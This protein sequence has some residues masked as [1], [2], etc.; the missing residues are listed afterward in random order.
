MFHLYL[1]LFSEDFVEDVY[2]LNDA[3]NSLFKKPEDVDVNKAEEEDEAKMKIWTRAVDVVLL[4][5]RLLEAA[6][7]TEVL[8]RSRD[9]FK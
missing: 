2:I 4:R 9:S 6:W 8:S 7:D 5:H 1:Q 3:V